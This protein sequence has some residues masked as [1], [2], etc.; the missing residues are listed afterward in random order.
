MPTLADMVDPNPSEADIEL[1]MPCGGKLVLKHVCVP[2]EGFFGD[3]RL[4]LGCIDCG[5]PDQSFMEGK[6]RAAIAGP[7]SLQDLPETWRS[8]LY[9]LAS[10][11]DGLCPKPHDNTQIGL[12][13][14]IG[15][16]EISNLQWKSVM[17]DSFSQTLKPRLDV[18][19][20]HIALYKNKSG[21]IN[22]EIIREDLLVLKPF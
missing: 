6:R 22:P 19:K 5:R 16:Y 18:Y 3:L 14:F 20:K 12:Y 15:K 11:G 13:Y 7:F 10:S 9:N 17:E 4:D 1:P 21:S 8:M 2:V